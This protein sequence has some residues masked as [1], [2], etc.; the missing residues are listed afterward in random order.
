MVLLFMESVMNN[1]SVMFTVMNNM[2]VL[3][4]VM[5]NMSVIFTV[6]NCFYF[7]MNTPHNIFIAKP[8]NIDIALFIAVQKTIHSVC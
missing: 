4:T 2:S 8:M 6:L 3:F 1:M 7:L 5:N